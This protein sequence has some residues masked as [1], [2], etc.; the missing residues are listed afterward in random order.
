VA[1][2]ESS[3]GFVEHTHTTEDGSATL[4]IRVPARELTPSLDR[5]QDRL[6]TPLERAKT[7]EELLEV[8][9]ELARVQT[10]IDKQEGRLELRRRG[11]GIRTTPHR[12]LYG[13]TRHEWVT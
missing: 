1:I 5:I 13:H 8:E 9:R 4:Q 12:T 3:G 6:R 2:A 7:V 10:E 11:A